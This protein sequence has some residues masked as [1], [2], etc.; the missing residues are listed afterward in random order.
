V[1]LGGKQTYVFLYETV[2]L[3]QQRYDVIFGVL[4]VFYYCELIL[5]FVV[6]IELLGLVNDSFVVYEIIWLFVLCC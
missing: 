4:I 6:L 1:S 2:G 3:L 5:L